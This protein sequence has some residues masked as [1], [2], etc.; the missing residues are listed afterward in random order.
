MKVLVLFHSRTG[1]N[2][3]SSR[4]IARVLKAGVMEIDESGKAR[5][6][7][8]IIK[9]DRLLF[10]F[11][12]HAFS[13]CRPIKEFFKDADLKGKKAGAVTVCGGHPWRSEKSFKKM[14][15]KANGVFMGFACIK[16]SGERAADD[17]LAVDKAKEIL[18]R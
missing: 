8:D 12:I 5:D 11:P 13:P 18:G 6:K 3:S 14:V 9:Y 2:R 7:E 15:E 16:D 17:K 4:A 10:C 1:N